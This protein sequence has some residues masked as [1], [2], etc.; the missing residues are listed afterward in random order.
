MYDLIVRRAQVH[1]GGGAA[2]FVADVGVRAGRILLVGSAGGALAAR[3][4]DGDGLALAPGFID[5]HSHADLTLPAFPQARNSIQQGVTTEVVGNCGFSAAPVVEAHAPELRRFVSGLGPHLDWSWTT[6]GE[7]V[8]ALDRCRPMVNVVPLVGHGALRL[9]AMS[10]ED[11]RPSPDELDVM[12]GLLRQSL[13]EGAW[14]LS[15]GLDYPPGTFAGSAE[16]VALGEVLAEANAG[17]FTHMRSGAATLEESLAEVMAVAAAGV[18]VHVSHLNSSAAVWHAVPLAIDRLEAARARGLAVHADAYPYTAGATY[19]SQLLP[20]WVGEGGTAAL[21]ARL[22]SRDER[23]RI[24]AAMHGDRAAPI[25]G[26]SF[27]DVL[28]TS[29]VLERNRRWEG[30]SLAE[31][32]R[33]SGSDPY[34]FL[35]DLLLDEEAGTV[36][37]VFT[38]R[39][40]DVRQALAWNG[41]AIGSDQ[42]GVFSDTARVHPRAYGTFARVLGRYVRET[43]LFSL[44]EAVRRMTGL[45]AA[46]LG[47][48]DRGHV[49]E[50]LVA[51]LVVFDATR[52]IDRSTY[53]EPTLPPV[54]IEYVVVNGTVVLDR[55]EV[56]G[57]RA[58]RSLRPRAGFGE[59]RLR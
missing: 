25:S 13:A 46:I 5:L 29:L 21:V 12:R 3:Q 55:R 47:L 20:T 10:F 8:D 38:M 4:I 24:R 27:D 18:R 57:V 54:G 43:G 34:E 33:A 52:V 51:D 53:Q 41:T 30:K 16:L 14:G 59:G 2:P 42:L 17:Y 39:E 28:L 58:G 40:E 50:G 48:S 32:A 23:A 37:V 36:M 45:P 26:A 15:S 35:F 11:R 6:F 31:A 56:T 9:A 19:L 49:R 22:R 7:Y 1:D 44:P